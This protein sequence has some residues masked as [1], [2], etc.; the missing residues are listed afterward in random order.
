MPWTNRASDEDA[1]L[2][3]RKEL[4]WHAVHRQERVALLPNHEGDHREGRSGGLLSPGIRR[5]TTPHTLRNE[6][7][8]CS[9]PESKGVVKVKNTLT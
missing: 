6:T 3:E 2:L 9:K 1:D 4:D 5:K 7:T 8:S